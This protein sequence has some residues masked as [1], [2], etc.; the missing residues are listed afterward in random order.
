MPIQT[1]RCICNFLEH[2]FTNA[3]QAVPI[4]EKKEV[5]ARKLNYYFGFA[6]MWGFGASYRTAA[7]RFIDNILR[8]FFGKLHFP[9]AE[10]VFEY[11]YHE[12]EQKFVH[13]S[14]NV[15]VFLYEPKLPFF[16]I[17]VPT[18]ETVRYTTLFDMLVTVG[19]PV[20]FTGST[21]VGKS[22]LVQNYFSTYQE[23][24][25]LAPV[26]LTFSA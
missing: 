3:K 2:L 24:H 13:W 12:K 5:W 9:M 26:Q 7:L 6:F 14:R 4:E 19:K 22:V 17:M 21:G 11:F 25:G 18:V 1:V 10:T 20:F 15:P 23:K 16:S 8:D